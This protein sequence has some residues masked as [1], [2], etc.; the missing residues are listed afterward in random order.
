MSKVPYRMSHFHPQNIGAS[1]D[2]RLGG[3]TWT[4]KRVRDSG[5]LLTATG[6]AEAL[7][8]DA[9]ADLLLHGIERAKPNPE[10]VEGWRNR[11]EAFFRR[12]RAQDAAS[13]AD[14]ANGVDGGGL[15]AAA[16]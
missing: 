9:L 13:P 3:I 16:E 6:A 1:A 14:T 7:A 2:T 8:P 5:K 4:F 12:E 10:A 11:E 15:C